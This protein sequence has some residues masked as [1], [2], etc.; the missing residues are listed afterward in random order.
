MKVGVAMSKR[1]VVNADTGE[2]ELELREGDR[3]V[4]DA[5]V[6]KLATMIEINKGRAYIKVYAESL[7]RI[8]QEND[9]SKTDLTVMFLLIPYIRF[10]SGLIAHDN[11][12]YL[13]LKSIVRMVGMS[14]RAVYGSIE[15]LVQK[16]VFAKV[17]TGRDV[18]LYAN[19]YVFMRGREVNRTLE[20]MFRASPYRE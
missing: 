2:Y 20:S 17:R 5:S 4:K 8:M 10:E 16:K 1:Y 13:T 19:P 9:L 14:E 18:K 6:K 11:G 7:L 15:K 3:I 12:K